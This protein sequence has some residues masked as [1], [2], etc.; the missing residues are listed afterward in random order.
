LS[1][2]NLLKRPFETG[3]GRL[4]PEKNPAAYAQP[5]Q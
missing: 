5:E 2:E 1:L 3:G 4:L